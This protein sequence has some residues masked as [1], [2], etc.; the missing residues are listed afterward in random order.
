MSLQTSGRLGRELNQCRV[1]LLDDSEG[2]I[3]L[4]IECTV[5]GEEMLLKKSLAR[6]PIRS[7]QK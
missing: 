2:S 7:E 5:N 1:T 4:G 3:D 6:V